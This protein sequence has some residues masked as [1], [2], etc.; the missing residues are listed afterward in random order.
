MLDATELGEIIEATQ[1]S[2]FRL[3]AMAEYNVTAADR[4]VTRYLA[5]EEPDMDRKQAW[6]DTL[7]ARVARGIELRHVRVLR[8]P[9]SDYDRMACEWG[10]DYNVQTGQQV[11]VWDT[12]RHSAGELAHID[13]AGDFYLL[14][15]GTLLQMFYN[16]A[17]GFTGALSPA[18]PEAVQRYGRLAARVWQ[19]AEPFSAW[20]TAHPQYHRQSL[21]S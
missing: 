10:F 17:G 1:R 7:R 6:L 8:T 12:S 19:E 2:I 20:W 5:G 3:E 13:A 18:E 14:D 15:S 11:R 16:E 21:S 4:D 9:L